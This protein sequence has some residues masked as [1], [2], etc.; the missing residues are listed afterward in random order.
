MGC[1][2]GDLVQKSAQGCRHYPVSN[3]QDIVQLPDDRI[4]V[5][6]ANGIYLIDAT[7]GNM[8][9]LDYKPGGRNNSDDIN[10]Y[11]H[12]LYIND[13]KELWI[14]T[15]GGGVYVYDLSQK[16]CRQLTTGNGLP[17]NSVSSINK[18]YKG[19]LLIAT[20][21]GLSFVAPS[22]QTADA[23]SDQIVDVNYC[24][25]IEREYSARAVVNLRNGHMLYGTT[26]GALIVNPDN[27]QKINYKTR[28]HLLGVSCTDDDC[29][30][31]KERIH[32]ML[33]EKSLRLHYSQR[34][35]D[36]FFESINLRNQFDIVYQYKVGEGEWSIPSDQQYIRFTNL[37]AGTHHLLLRSVSRT[38]GA[39]LDE[40]ALT[41]TV[42]EPWWNSWWMWVV[43]VSL[44]ALAFFGAW[45][46]YQLHTKY[47]R[48]VV[49]SLEKDTE[50]LDIPKTHEASLPPTTS[51]PDLQTTSSS[52]GQTVMEEASDA[53][54]AP[55]PSDSSDSSE[56]SEF[57][58]KVTKIVSAH[59]SDADFNIDR[60]CREMAMS[61]TLF[62]IKLKTYTGNSPQ[63]FIRVIRLERA[64]ALLRGGHSVTE[65]AA[66]AGFENVKYFSTVFKKYF[67][68]SPSKYL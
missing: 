8:V 7:T 9:E 13:S 43:Y 18:D 35:F 29:E 2:D 44:V 22:D 30:L 19:R 54:E 23:P 50:S 1:L 68:L 6:T 32:K 15:D 12:T 26:S 53:P 40:V 27:I 10:K 39:V 3:V 38:C 56:S 51:L 16:S 48:L 11:I 14:G 64:A 36:L 45:R 20:D 34:T 57:I 31:F 58:E 52:D 67:G 28:L 65:T 33:K 49:S 25:G 60:L 41:V 24:Y 4:A 17:S 66:L 47:M 59:L 63:D 62:Y 61:R 55:K 37:E 5:G 42:A 46:V 21:N